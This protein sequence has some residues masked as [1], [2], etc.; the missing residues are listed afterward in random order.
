MNIARRNRFYYVREFTIFTIEE[1]ELAVTKMN[2]WKAPDPDGIRSK[3]L[4]AVSRQKTE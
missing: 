2:D 4:H 1:L 3:V